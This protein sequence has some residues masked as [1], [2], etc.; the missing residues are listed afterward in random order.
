MHIF[1]HKRHCY[2]IFIK[3]IDISSSL[4]NSS[5]SDSDSESSDSD[6]DSDLDSDLDSESSDADSDSDLDSESSDSDSD[7]DLYFSSSVTYNY[8][9]KCIFWGSNLNIHLCFGCW[10]VW[11][12]LY[13]FMTAE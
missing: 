10:L 6:S 13:I 8:I 4:R 12:L 1:N 9:L 3:F 2:F 5:D 7:L 11:L